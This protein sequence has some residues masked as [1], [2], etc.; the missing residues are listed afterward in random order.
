MRAMSG[1][2]AGLALTCLAAS[3]DGN[4]H[5]LKRPHADVVLVWNQVLLDSNAIDSTLTIPDQPGP[6][7]TSRAFAIV[8]I[9][10]FEACN[11][12]D[13]G[14]EPYGE[15][16]TEFRKA[17][18]DA[19]VA[20][21]AFE[22]LCVLYPQQC[23][24]FEELYDDWMSRIK[25]DRAR[26]LGVE[27]G[28]LAAAGILAERAGDGS[29]LSMLYLPGSGPGYH[30]VDPLN[31]GQGYHAPHWGAVAPFAIG[32][33]DNFAAPPPPAL[34]SYDYYL[35]YLEVFTLGGDDP[36]TTLRTAEQTETGI[37]WAYDGTPGLGKPPRL[38]N[39]VVR[40]IAQDR[41]NSTAENA[42]LF[43][44]VNI[45]MADAG[46]QAWSTKYQYE[47][48][49]PVVAIRA[50][51]DDGNP[52]TI[53]D[54]DW[55][56]LGAPFTNG[57]AG[58]PNFT[59]PFPAYTSGHATFGAAAL[60]TV[61]RFYGTDE[62]R[63]DFMSDEF[64]GLNADQNGNVR[65]VVVR[66]YERLSDAILENALSR[67]YLGIHW[68]FDADEGIRSGM[69]IADYVYSSVLRQQRRGGRNR[70]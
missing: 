65:P 42:R 50:G 29:G 64:N 44:L 60:W 3:A 20:T 24:R 31:P 34:N 45:A 66:H 28:Q 67:I 58:A 57:P 15:D 14:C 1:F 38:Y 40:V 35:A 63:F 53:G 4:D 36:E 19:A 10:M 69:D 56:P 30:Q 6:T 41:R 55:A 52:L 18:T 17:N 2:I 37:F 32:D 43:A 70:R 59:P 54:S 23:A 47:F 9:A 26:D 25:R 16:L 12:I 7:Y 22:T 8:S 39:Q 61:A 21:A 13:G 68:R 48:W 27:L 46:I 62:I 33:V 51:E 49:R 11:A 5:H